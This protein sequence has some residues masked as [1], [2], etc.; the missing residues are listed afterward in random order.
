[1]NCGS[2]A[3][4]LD[5]RH[6]TFASVYS[7]R[8]VAILTSDTEAPLNLN[9]ENHVF[10]PRTARTQP[11]T[12]RYQV[13]AVDGDRERRRSAERVTVQWCQ[14]HKVRNG[15]SHLP[16]EKHASVRDAMRAAYTSSTTA[17]AKRS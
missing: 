16:D 12:T 1:V 13:S 5:V 2:G 9:Y 17:T 11:P 8:R 6:R 15:L 14:V 4:D 10:L 7:R 3:R